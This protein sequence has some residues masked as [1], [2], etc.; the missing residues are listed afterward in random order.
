MK[1]L[2]I[3]GTQF[4]GR[5]LTGMALERGDEVTIFHRGS[6]TDDVYPEAEPHRKV[7]TSMLLQIFSSEAL[8]TAGVR[9]N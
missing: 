9:R 2:V 4:S 7:S 6:G 3:G 1:L 5:A 8:R